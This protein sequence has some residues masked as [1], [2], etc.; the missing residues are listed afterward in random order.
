MFEQQVTVSNKELILETDRPQG[1][2]GKAKALFNEQTTPKYAFDVICTSIPDNIHPGQRIKFEVGIR[3][4]SERTTA[5][6]LPNITLEKCKVTMIACMGVKAFD[7]GKETEPLT[8][9]KDIA[10]V[11]GSAPPRAP[12][13]KSHDY[14][15]IVSTGPF[16]TLMSTIAVQKLSRNYRIRVDLEFLTCK[17]PLIARKEFPIMIHPPSSSAIPL[18]MPEA[19]P[20]QAAQAD[21]EPLPAYEEV[22]SEV[23]GPGRTA[24]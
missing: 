23:D 6:S 16:P 18:S 15:K 9:R 21:E 5:K 22:P 24:D 20:S 8:D 13:S 12:Y 19:G 3:I 4:N 11:Q 7:H 17:Q 10:T 1:F 2:K 14:T